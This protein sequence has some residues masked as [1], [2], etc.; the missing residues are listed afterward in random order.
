MIADFGITSHATTDQ[1]VPTYNARGTGGYR[2]PELLTTPPAFTKKVDIWALGCILYELLTQQKAFA[3]DWKVREY[4]MTASIKLEIR[5]EYGFQELSEH[6]TNLMSQLLHRDPHQR[7]RVSDLRRLLRSYTIVWSDPVSQIISELLDPEFRTDEY[8]FPPFSEWVSIVKEPFSRGVLLM[9]LSEWYEGRHWLNTAIELSNILVSEYPQADE[10][11]QRLE[12]LYK[13]RGEPM[14]AIRGWTSLVERHPG[15]TKL[16][17]VLT[18]TCIAMGGVSRAAS[19]W[20]DIVKRNPVNMQFTLV[21]AQL[22]AEACLESGVA[23][24]I[25]RAVNIWGAL[26]EKHPRVSRLHGQLKAALKA[27]GGGTHWGPHVWRELVRKHPQE[28]ELIFE[29]RMA[30]EK[31]DEVEETV[32]I[33]VDLV[34]EHPE[35]PELQ[36]ELSHALRWSGNS[37]RTVD[38]WEELR[39]RCPENKGLER[40]WEQAC[41]AQQEE[42]SSIEE[43]RRILRL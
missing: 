6:E 10:Y 13:K 31:M 43:W 4:H 35:V 40:E 19:V 41:K 29:L 2:A 20:A 28:K 42:G 23:E 3:D 1:A 7:P 25:E 37:K 26:V 30:C 32:E 22:D 9:R 21:Y 39:K 18:E 24:D 15:N 8:K 34:K 27:A 11:R 38:T 14:L 17:K 5:A 33:W 36:S 16:H 12:Y